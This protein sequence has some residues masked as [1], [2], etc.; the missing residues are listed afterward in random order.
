M[1]WGTVIGRN[2]SSPPT[3]YQSSSAERGPCLARLSC[4]LVTIAILG[5]EGVCLGA[6]A[7]PQ[8]ASQAAE[9]TPYYYPEL[10]LTYVNAPYTSGCALF[11]ISRSML[12]NR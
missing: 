12:D 2:R 6:D 1:T 10:A 3:G 7:T 11:H 9:G 4:S 8:R 5:P